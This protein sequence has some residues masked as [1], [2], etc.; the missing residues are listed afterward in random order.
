MHDRHCPFCRTDSGVMIHDDDK[1]RAYECETCLALEWITKGKHSWWYHGWQQLDDGDT[2]GLRIN[3]DGIRGR[4]PI[5]YLEW[6]T[7]AT[8]S[9]LAALST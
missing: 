8:N 4:A 6:A 9:N 5:H 1:T 7:L 2:P 3:G